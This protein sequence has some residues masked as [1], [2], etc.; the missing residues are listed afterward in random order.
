MIYKKL[1]KDSNELCV[2]DYNITDDDM[3]P[4]KKKRVK[5]QNIKKVCKELNKIFAHPKLDRM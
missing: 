1:K 4:K 5:R 3:L 2:T